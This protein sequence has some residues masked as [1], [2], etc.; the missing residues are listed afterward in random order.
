VVSA[1]PPYLGGKLPLTPFAAWSG[2][3]L[4]S[5]QKSAKILLTQRNSVVESFRLRVESD[6]GVEWMAKNQGPVDIKRLIRSCD[7]SMREAKRRLF[8][9]STRFI[10]NIV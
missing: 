7:T 2:G 10:N 9:L 3:G 5:Y 6:I 1:K 8:F 4:P